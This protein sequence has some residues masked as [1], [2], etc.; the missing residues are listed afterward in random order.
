MLSGISLPAFSHNR[1]KK[2]EGR[3][4]KEEGRRKKQSNQGFQKL[5]RVSRNRVFSQQYFVTADKKAKKPGFF[6]LAREAE[7][8]GFSRV[9]LVA[10]AR[11]LDILPDRRGRG[12]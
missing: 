9:N 12:F 1:R 2:E 3:G 5:R 6:G 4:E 10:V 8:P 11:F 7:K